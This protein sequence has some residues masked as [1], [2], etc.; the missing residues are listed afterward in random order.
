MSSRTSLKDIADV[1]CVSIATVS[2][3]LRNSPRISEITRAR[4]RKIAAELNYRPDPIISEIASRRWK[5]GSSNRANCVFIA[6]HNPVNEKPGESLNYILQYKGAQSAASTLGYSVDHLYFEAEPDY[7]KLAAMLRARGVTGI[8][9]S[10]IYHRRIFEH[11]DLSAFSVVCADRGHFDPP[12]DHVRHD[13]AYS[14][15]GA[16]KKALASGRERIGVAILDEPEALDRQEKIATALYYQQSVPEAQKV[17]ILRY[18]TNDGASDICHWF[19]KYRP[20]VVIGFNDGVYSHL[21]RQGRYS[22][23][24]DF[25]FI[26][27]N[28]RYREAPRENSLTGYRMN[29]ELLGETAFRHL[30]QLIRHNQRGRPA[31]NQINLIK[32]TFYEGNTFPGKAR[33]KG[34]VGHPQTVEESNSEALRETFA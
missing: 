1:A 14:M 19:R 34:F 11:L 32:P 8:L 26:S 18:S 29:N 24:Q 6:F 27:L 7:E 31:F 30:D 16:W 4:I 2:L 23:P 25:S 10:Q 3:A 17:P 9:M 20:S 12:Y 13:M 28:K 21:Y 5:E 33:P 15:E 22:A